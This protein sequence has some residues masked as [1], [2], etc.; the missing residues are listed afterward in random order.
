M[1]TTRSE[2]RGRSPGERRFVGLQP[3]ASSAGVAAVGRWIILDEALVLGETAENEKRKYLA[4]AGSRRQ[5][6]GKRKKPE[7]RLRLKDPW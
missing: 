4:E 2:P 1:G 5:V 6:R 7:D 3:C